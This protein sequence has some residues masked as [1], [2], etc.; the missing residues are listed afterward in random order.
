[1]VFFKNHEQRVVLNGLFSSCTNVNTGVPQGS[2][3]EPIVFDCYKRLAKR[4]T[5]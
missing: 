2:I 5:V 4:F 3:Y 1:M